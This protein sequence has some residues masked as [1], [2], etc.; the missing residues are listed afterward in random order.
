MEK[1]LKQIFSVTNKNNHKV[2][3]ILGL[4]I[5]FKHKHNHVLLYKQNGR[6]VKN[7]KIKG[8]KIRFLGSNAKVEI[9]EPCKFNNSKIHL[10][11]EAYVCIKQT[12]YVYNN[13]FINADYSYGFKMNIGENTSCGELT[14]RSAAGSN[15]SVSIG[16]ECAFSTG[17]MIQPL[18]GHWIYPRGGGQILNL[19]IDGVSVGDHV[20]IGRDVKIGKNVSIPNNSIIGM[21]SIVTKS[22]NEE[23]IIL[24][25][26]PAKVVSKDKNWKR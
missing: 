5:K 26:V 9:Y 8:L 15:I 16:R 2:W 6:V 3:R 20:W 4:K 11:D 7:A 14:I 17:V 13:L 21:G 10:S 19:P 22:F 1:I 25:G 24:A 12:Q 23:N 18:D